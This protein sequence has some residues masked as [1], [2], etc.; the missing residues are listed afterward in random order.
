MSCPCVSSRL[1]G[2]GRDDPLLFEAVLSSARGDKKAW[3]VRFP[4]T[5]PQQTALARLCVSLFSTFTV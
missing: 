2:Q 4:T 5:N 3:L 1:L